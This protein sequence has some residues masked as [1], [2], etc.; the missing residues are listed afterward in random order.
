MTT[1]TNDFLPFATDPSAP[2]A[3]QGAYASSNPQLGRGPGILPKESFNK[4]A[5]QGNSMASAIGSFI[6]SRGF[7][8]LDNGDVA[9]LQAALTAALSSLVSSSIAELST[10]G[11]V[12]GMVVGPFTVFFGQAPLINV[13]SFT[14]SGATITFPHGGFPTSCLIV[15]AT[16]DFAEGSSS[17]GAQRALYS[18]TGAG[19]TYANNST[20]SQPLQ[21]NYLAIGV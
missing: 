17:V 19:L 5:R 16:L 21:A 20:S 11:T 9:G 13:P 14:T 15:M 1:G 2:V 18:R 8:A 7:N 4:I 6:A 12:D 3:T 10:S